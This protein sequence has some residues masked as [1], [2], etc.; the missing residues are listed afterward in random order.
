M[1]LL[2]PFPFWVAAEQ[3]GGGRVKVNT[4]GLTSLGRDSSPPLTFRLIWPYLC[5]KGTWKSN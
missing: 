2:I 5:W 3:K 4:A 1:S